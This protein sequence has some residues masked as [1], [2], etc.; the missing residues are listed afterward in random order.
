M[1]SNQISLPFPASTVLLVR[2]SIAG[3][4]V[5]MVMRN[6]KIDFAYGAL[7]FPGGKLDKHDSNPELLELCRSQ[8][9]IFDDLAGRICGIRETFEEAGILLARDE[10]NDQMINGER[11]AELTLRYRDALHS[12]KITLLEILKK[13]KIKLACDK[14][15][16]FAR[17]VTPSSFSR[18]F[19]ARFYI[20][21]TP[22]DY[23]AK[24]D[25]IE[26]VSSMWTSPITALEEADEGRA[27]LVFATRMNLTKIAH[28]DNVS[29]LIEATEKRE[30]VTVEPQISQ[31]RDEVTYKIPIE[32]G[33]G[34]TEFIEYGGPS[35]KIK[36]QK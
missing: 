18:R 7:V 22:A 29:N 31:S 33:Y 25:G 21:K 30:V 26:S 8:G 6:R 34:I 3:P 13:E 36:S 17:W 9:L 5:F 35:L 4:E 24:H 27:T 12:G 1:T 23:V 2:D 15:I 19:D 14:L 32:A 20:S 11:C 28:F 16:L 10:T